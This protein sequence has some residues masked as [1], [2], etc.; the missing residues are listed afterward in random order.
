MSTIY[1]KKIRLDSIEHTND[2][3]KNNSFTGGTVM[4]VA[5]PAAFAVNSADQGNITFQENAAKIKQHRVR[6]DQYQRQ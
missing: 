6:S 5:A 2:N 1:C 4:T 3:C